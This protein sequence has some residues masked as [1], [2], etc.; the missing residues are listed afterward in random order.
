MKRGLETNNSLTFRPVDTFERKNAS[1]FD[2]LKERLSTTASNVAPEIALTTINDLKCWCTFEAATPEELNQH[3]QT[4]H[5]ALSVSEG[6]SRCP[7]CRRRCKSFSD[8]QAHKRV[9]CSA[10]SRAKNSNE[11]AE[12]AENNSENQTGSFRGEY[13]FPAQLDWDASYGEANSF[14]NSVR[15][16]MQLEIYRMKYSNSCG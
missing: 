1:F 11:N 2:K 15:N 4:H 3:K 14:G 16:F 13:A 12:N 8:L 9:C 5:T 7:T 6:T 10:E